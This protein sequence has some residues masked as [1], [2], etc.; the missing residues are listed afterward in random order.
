M[1]V[2]YR[3]AAITYHTIAAYATIVRNGRHIVAESCR[4]DDR[5]IQRSTRVENTQSGRSIDCTTPASTN[6]PYVRR[7]SREAIESGVAWRLLI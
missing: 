4:T 5:Y 7:R 1:I 2:I 6:V 3:Y